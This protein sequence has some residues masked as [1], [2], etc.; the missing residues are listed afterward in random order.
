MS[1]YVPAGRG[2]RDLVL[3]PAILRELVQQWIDMRR[4]YHGRLRV[5]WHDCRVALLV[6]P[7]EQDRYTGCGA[8][9][10]TAR[11]KVDGTLTPCVFLPNAAGNLLNQSFSEIWKDSP[12]L[13]QI[14]D[15][16]TLQSGNCGA[17][18]FK[19]ICGGCRATSMSYY[20]DP[21]M[22]DP[23]CWIKPQTETRRVS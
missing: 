3:P 7:E 12:L 8:G 17:C 23:S 1:E 14:R 5:I 4:E 20:G 15:R 11:I 18:E 22:G 19:F 9:T 6:P 10:L 13:K 21:A 16:N 2:T